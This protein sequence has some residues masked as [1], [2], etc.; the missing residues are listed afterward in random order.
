MTRSVEF[1]ALGLAMERKIFEPWRPWEGSAKLA[2]NEKFVE[3]NNQ[4][5]VNEPLTPELP[6][7]KKELQECITEVAAQLVENSN[8]KDPENEDKHP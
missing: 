7:E 1:R 3:P 2:E 6:A 5:S 8:F 4:Q